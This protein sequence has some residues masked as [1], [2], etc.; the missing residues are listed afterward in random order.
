MSYLV[1]KRWI[2]REEL[3]S[4]R[5]EAKYIEDYSQNTVLSL[6]ED[7]ETCFIQDF[8]IGMDHLL[9]FVSY[10]FT[11]YTRVF[12]VFTLHLSHHCMLSV[13]GRVGAV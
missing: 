1:C 5:E 11:F 10:P 9:L 4:Q 8:R 3:T 13:W 12:I 7:L 6:I 2:Q